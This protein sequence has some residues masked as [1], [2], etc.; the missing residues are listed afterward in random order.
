M[1]PSIHFHHVES[2]E[3]LAQDLAEFVAQR[4]REGLATRGQALLVVSGGSTPMPFFK[5]LSGM[6]LDWSGVWVTLADERWLPPDHAYSNERLVRQGLLQ[7]QAAQA[8]LLPLFN[9]AA[10]PEAA[11]VA[12]EGALASLPWPADVV[13][14]GMGG[15]GHTASLF[16]HAPELA[17]A[18]AEGEGPRC[19]PVAVP[20]APNVPVPRLSLTR[21]ALLDTRQLVVHITGASKLALV[22]QAMQEGPV[23]P[24]PIRLALHQ[25]RVPCEV[26][27]AA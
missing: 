5:A 11:Q 16:P 17:A 18:L 27:H 10:S 7:G 20:A 6:A 25:S 2:A 24:W 14:L 9:G 8:R 22:E 15:D 21:R 4:L 13:V 12:V 3:V 19:L 1:L 26:F 23:A